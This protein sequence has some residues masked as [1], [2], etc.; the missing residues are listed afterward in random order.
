MKDKKKSIIIF[1]FALF[2]SIMIMLSINTYFT[3]KEIT[4]ATNKCYDANG[5]PTVSK[6][7]FSIYWSFSCDLP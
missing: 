4:H 3:H 5:S 6:S 1:S 7:S 2:F